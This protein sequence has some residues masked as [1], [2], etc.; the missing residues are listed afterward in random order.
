VHPRAGGGGA[1]RR[2]GPAAPGRC[3]CKAPRWMYTSRMQGGHCMPHARRSRC[4]AHKE[5]LTSAGRCACK[6]RGD[7]AQPPCIP[8]TR[9]V[10]EGL[11]TRIVHEGLCTRIVHEGL[12]TRIVQGVI[13]YKDCT[14]GDHTH[15]ACKEVNILRIHEAPSPSTRERLGALALQPQVYVEG[16]GVMRGQT[17]RYMY[18]FRIH[19]GVGTH[20]ACKGPRTQRPRTEPPGRRPLPQSP[21]TRPVP[22]LAGGPP[23]TPYRLMAWH[24]LTCQG[25][26]RLTRDERR[27]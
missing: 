1:P 6:A 21:P 20:S 26:E 4:S 2:P 15:P 12:C 23:S 10:H 7:C 14:R 11:C 5:V 13:V 3:A 18:A 25:A 16:P 27:A 19:G 22:A 8:R 24:S 17:R 9:I